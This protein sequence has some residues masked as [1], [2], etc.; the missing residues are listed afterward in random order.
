M[1]K[2]ARRT[3]RKTARNA[4]RRTAKRK[5]TRRTSSRSA[6]SRTASRT[7]RRTTNRRATKRKTATSRAR[8][9]KTARSTRASRSARTSRT[10]RAERPLRRL[11]PVA[12]REMTRTVK[13]VKRDGRSEDFDRE[14]IRRG[15]IRAAQRANISEERAREL[16][17]RVSR[18]IE[19]Q[20]RDSITSEEIRNR[21]IQ[22]LEREERELAN[23]FR[24][25]RQMGF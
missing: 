6:R 9:S 14:K 23:S 3:V 20:A 7:A 11:L 5:S 21:L 18:T 19:N 15:I 2:A 25:F 24:S 13:V 1:V 22:E 8:S 16:A 4:A 17:D 12:S 10:T